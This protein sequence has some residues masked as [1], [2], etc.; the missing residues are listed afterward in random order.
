MRAA[1][2]L[3]K[4]RDGGELTPAEV[5]AFVSGATDG[6]WADY[7]LTALL[8]AV[9]CR[10]MTAAETAELTRAMTDSG[11]RVDLSDLPGPKVD[12][13]STGGVGDKTS[14]VLGPLAAA[15][16]VV[17]PMMS[18]RGLGH[19]GGTLDKLEAI[20][21]FRVNLSV[22]EFR[23][24]LREVGLAMIGQTADVAPADKKLYSLRDVTGTVE[25]VPLITASIL[26]K[27]IAEGISGLVLDVK[28]GHGA[29]MKTLPDARTL[30]ESLVRVGTANGLRVE[31]VL[32]GMDA[33]LGRAVGN[34]LEVIEAIDTLKGTGPADTEHLSVLLAAAMVRL[35]GLAA[36]DATAEGMVRRA[37]ESGAGL[38]V[39]R[40]AIEFQ[41][42]DPRVIDDPSRLPL[43]RRSHLV[44][45]DRDGYVTEVRAGAVGVAATVLGAGRERAE[46]AVDH[47]VG[48]LVLARPGARVRA[49][50]P[51]LEAVYRDAQKLGDALP[52]LEDAVRI[53][54]APPTPAP[55]VLETVR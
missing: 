7:Q 10:G 21:G 25:S 48:V 46:D 8:M 2:I 51:V 29:F 31:A 30:A 37:L 55:L 11:T 54:D 43:T 38:E 50:E 14:L 16:G 32:T 18:G 17:V 35:A 3:R 47:A 12:K 15:C 27:K 28:A 4:K 20:P 33:P 52:L 6:S 45:A 53:G 5:A 26:S 41:G 44:R 36:D 42:G 22:R 24:A 1:D 40:R 19:T 9:C 23:I 13:H 39:F 49:D 34:S